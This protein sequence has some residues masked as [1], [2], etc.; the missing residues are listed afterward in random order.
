[1]AVADSYEYL[2]KLSLQMQCDLLRAGL[3]PGA[4]KCVWDPVKVIDWNGLTFDF[5]RKGIAIKADRIKKFKYHNMSLMAKWPAVSFR[6]V[7]RCTG[8]LNSMYPVLGGSVQIR[9]KMLQTIVNIRNYKNLAWDDRIQVDFLPLYFHAFAELEYWNVHLEA[10]N[11]RLFSPVKPNFVAWTDAS[12]VALGACMIKMHEN[13]SIVPVT[14]DNVLLDS[15]GVYTAL[16]RHVAL[17]AGEY[18]WRYHGTVIVRDFLDSLV[19][20]TEEMLNCHRNFSPEEQATSS[21]ERE[22]LAIYHCIVSTA[23]LLKGKCVTVHTDSQNAESIC[24]K[25]SQKPKLQAYAKLIDHVLDKYSINLNVVWVPRDLNLVAD[26]ISTEIDYGDYEIIGTKFK[27]ICTSLNRFPDVDCFANNRN[28]K[29]ETFFSPAM[30][31]DTSGVDAFCY[32]WGEFGLC[33]I[34]VQP[35]MICRALIYARRC[36]ANILL[37]VPQ[38]K[39]S[40]FYPLLLDYS[41]LSAFQKVSVFP[42]K[43]LFKAGF[44]ANTIFSDKYAGNVEVWHFSF[45]N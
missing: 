3:V 17:H 38:W 25:G 19:D 29:C 33:W 1:M 22:L 41:K 35:S 28:A 39:N 11:F 6:E 23:H 8:R 27:E 4:K 15:T 26:F 34:F 24:T 12:D 43:G 40:Y 31:P 2:S 16:R 42:G 10:K 44:D 13:Q 32:N 9:T 14:I 45:A 5:M 37:L 21:T 7:A 30:C 20:N 18:V 36:K